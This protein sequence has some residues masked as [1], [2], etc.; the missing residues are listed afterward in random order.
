MN[1]LCAKV[2][3]YIKW[4]KGNEAKETVQEFSKLRN[5]PFPG[6]FAAVDGCHI[7]IPSPVEDKA[8]YYNRKGYHSIVLQGICDAK[9]KFINVFVG[10][11][12]STHDARIWKN[13]P[14]YR[15][16]TSQPEEFLPCNSHLLGDSAYPCDTFL[17]CPYKDN[18][19][20]TKV[21]K[22]FNVCLSSSRVVIEQAYGLLKGR[23]RRL[24]YLDMVDL[25]L[26]T[27]VVTVACIMHN[28]C[29]D[30]NEDEETIDLSIDDEDICSDCDSHSVLG[31][32]KRDSIAAVL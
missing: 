25:K 31:N 3:N 13:S 7:S 14:I 12:G 29:I 9:L 2:S 17:M 4:P 5:K 23:F 6:M 15:L 8:S 16:L 26:A 1:T 21:Q 20:L 10:W 32:A 28:L 11:P 19:H 27:K 30:N 18:G 24:K 22:R